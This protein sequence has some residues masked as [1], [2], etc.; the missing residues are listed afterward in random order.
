MCTNSQV[1]A[2]SRQLAKRHRILYSL[3]KIID[4]FAVS[5]TSFL[6][7]RYSDPVATLSNVMNFVI[8]SLQQD[9]EPQP[10]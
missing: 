2:A 9:N 6:H 10:V 1:M 8:S 3:C 5:V 4:E 7:P